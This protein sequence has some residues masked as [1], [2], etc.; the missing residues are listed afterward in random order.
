MS[1]TKK[2]HHVSI[3]V[4]VESPAHGYVE[5]IHTPTRGS[6]GTRPETTEEWALERH[7]HIEADVASPHGLVKRQP[8]PTAKPVSPSFEAD[9]ARDEEAAAKR[10]GMLFVLSIAAVVTAAIVLRKA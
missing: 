8:T 2:R 9:L 6:S 3:A 10:R 7:A 5:K 4:G 1:D